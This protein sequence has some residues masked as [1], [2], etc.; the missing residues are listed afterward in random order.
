VRGFN[1]IRPAAVPRPDLLIVA[2]GG[3]SIEDL[4][5]LQRGGGGA[6]HRRMRRSRDQR[7]RARDRHH[8]GIDFAADRRAPTPTAAAEMAVPVRADLSAPRRGRIGRGNR[9]HPLNPA[10][11]TR[12]EMVRRC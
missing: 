7:G 8:A 9:E 5:A 1:A 3:G 10:C 6:R 2:R 12:I 4:W 11:S